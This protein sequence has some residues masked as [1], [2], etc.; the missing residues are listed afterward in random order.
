MKDKK[1]SKTTI[2][3]IIALVVVLIGVLFFEKSLKRVIPEDQAYKIAKASGFD[4]NRV[5]NYYSTDQTVAKDAVIFYDKKGTE[6]YVNLSYMNSE[7]EAQAV[8]RETLEPIKV[9]VNTMGY[10]PTTKK[11]WNF[12]SYELKTN[13]SYDYIAVIKDSVL[14]IHANNN[15]YTKKLQEYTKNIHY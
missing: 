11:K 12:E 2:G 7:A 15:K 8:M 5:S 14:V 3:I 10:T 13:N 9:L 1:I 4:P 6:Y